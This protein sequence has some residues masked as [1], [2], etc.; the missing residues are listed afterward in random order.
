MVRPAARREAVTFLLKEFDVSER[1]ACRVVGLRRS[2]RRCEPKQLELPGLRDAIREVAHEQPRYGYRRVHWQVREQGFTVGQRQVR[3]IYAQEGL[4]VRRR[5][6]R[7]LKPVA[8]R[9][10]VPPSRPGERWSMDFIHD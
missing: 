10:L 6:R 5:R 1:R 9:P 4:S 7:R 8:R 2:T 3:R